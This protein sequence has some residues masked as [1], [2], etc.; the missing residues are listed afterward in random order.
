MLVALLAALAAAGAADARATVPV[1]GIGDQQPTMF[2]DPLWQQLRLPNV[3]VIAA[4][5]ALDSGWQRAE[6]DAYMAAAHTAGARVLLG[7]GHS[8]VDAKHHHLPTVAVYTKELKRLRARYPWV[9]DFITWNEEDVC[10]EPTCKNPERAADFYLAAKRT[11]PGCKIV[12]A[13]LLDSSRMLPWIK[14]FLK[15]IGP[16]HKLTWGLHNYID[17]NRF[18]TS[19]TQALLKATKGDVWFTETAG[20]VMRDNGSKI[21]FPGSIS[22]AAKATTQVFR[23]AKLSP[24]VKRIY[25]YQWAPSTDPDPTWDSALVNAHDQARPAYKVLRTWLRAHPHS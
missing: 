20:L 13:D 16:G 22:H 2:S 15:R 4:Y 1:I 7:I 23:L 11:C 8:R 6:L 21:L 14:R 18:R 17:A 5:D 12:A 19:G 10:G 9:H 24:R 25:F 3:R